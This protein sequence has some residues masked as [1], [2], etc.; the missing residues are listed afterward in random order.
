MFKI[1]CRNTLSKNQVTRK[2]EPQLCRY[3]IAASLRGMLS[4]HN[5]TNWLERTHSPR[6]AWCTIENEPCVSAA[7]NPHKPN[8]SLYIVL[9]LTR[10]MQTWK[11]RTVPHRASTDIQRLDGF[12]PIRTSSFQNR[13]TL[14]AEAHQGMRSW[15]DVPVN[16]V[17]L[18]QLLSLAVTVTGT[19]YSARAASP[20]TSRTCTEMQLLWP[21]VSEPW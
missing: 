8:P 1:P 19:C 2:I 18:G 13:S 9:Q 3:L 11:I 6:S 4:C 5:S 10:Y 17:L 20:S 14:T 21:N 12:R 7:L 15:L 16:S